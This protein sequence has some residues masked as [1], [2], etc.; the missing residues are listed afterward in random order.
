MEAEKIKT[1]R[2]GF[3][4]H[5]VGAYVAVSALAAGSAAADPI[6]AAI[7]ARRKALAALDAP[8]RRTTAE[9]TVLCHAECRATIEA[10]TTVP[11]TTEGF[12]AFCEFGMELHDEARQASDYGL[13]DWTPG[14]PLNLPLPDMERMYLTTLAKAARLLIPASA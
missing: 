5:I 3:A 7:D 11:T 6:F 1:S 12:R 10:V 4:G 13:A 8:G 2:R 9:D 14:I